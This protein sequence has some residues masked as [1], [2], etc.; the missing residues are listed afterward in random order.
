MS[1][2]AEPMLPIWAGVRANAVINIPQPVA[3]ITVA[4]INTTR[5][6]AS[7][8]FTPKNNVLARIKMPTCATPIKKIPSTFPP[9]TCAVDVGDTSRR[10]SVPCE[11]SA[12]IERPPYE[13]VYI[14]KSNAIAGA[15]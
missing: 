3:P 6:A 10:G 15:I 4:T 8:H 1:M 14:K 5:P 12:R 2:T 11:R 9:S 13:T 7:P